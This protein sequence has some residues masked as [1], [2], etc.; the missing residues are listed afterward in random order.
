MLYFGTWF[1][2]VRVHGFTAL[3]ASETMAEI[4]PQDSVSNVNAEDPN[5]EEDDSE[6]GPRP[7]PPSVNPDGWSAPGPKSDPRWVGFMVKSME[8]H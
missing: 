2:S 4:T 1:V 3:D 7:L 5:E 6:L 8:V